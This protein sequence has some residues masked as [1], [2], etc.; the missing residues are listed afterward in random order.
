[1]STLSADSRPSK[2]EHT[3]GLWIAVRCKHGWHIGPQPDG[4]CTIHDN[5]D[6]SNCEQHEANARL[7]AAAPDLLEV[8]HVA[9]ELYAKY[10]L[11]AQPEASLNVEQ[12]INDLR[13]AIAKAESTQ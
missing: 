6:R 10:A 2:P 7:I 12:W 13:A 5:T 9:N 4:V 11:L 8:C 3:S 1:M